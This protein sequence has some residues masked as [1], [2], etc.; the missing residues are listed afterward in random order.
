MFYSDLY[1]S[2]SFDGQMKWDRFIICLQNQ[3]ITIMCQIC[4]HTYAGSL[5]KR[6]EKLYNLFQWFTG[7]GTAMTPI[8]PLS[9]LLVCIVR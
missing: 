3:G 9:G 8:P 2:V 7:N 1:V 5:W 6:T 4:Y